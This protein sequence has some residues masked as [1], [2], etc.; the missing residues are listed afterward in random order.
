MSTKNRAWI[1][2]S[3]PKGMVT[4]DN[5]ELRESPVDTPSEGEFLIRT[6]WLSVDPYMRGRMN[7]RRTYIDPVALE[8]VMCG[9]G[10]GVVIE[11]KNSE[12]PVGCYVCGEFGWQEYVATNGKGMR[13]VDPAL[14]PLSTALGVLGMPG[15]TAYFGLLDIGKPQTGQTVVVSGA[16]GAVGATVG[17][18]AKI[19][20]CRVVGIA[21]SDE[22]VNYL[23][24]ELGFDAAWN[25]KTVPNYV[26]KLK[27]TCPTGIDIYFDNVGGPITDAVFHKINRKARI[28]ICG[29]IAQYNSSS[30][31]KGERFLWKLI[32][33]R[34][35]V[36]GFLVFDYAASYP[37]ADRQL[38]GWFQEGKLKYREKITRGL[39][40]TPQAFI[41]LFT[42]EN[43]GKQLVQVAD[44]PTR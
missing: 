20:G 7:D 13:R 14:A 33:T 11:S 43:I 35:R 23:T 25:Y 4:T 1:L 32:E 40:L 15:R 24:Q 18:I 38:I 42:G 8:S 29:Q 3:R 44:D 26:E 41:G 22:K 21:G 31:E 2:K 9:S 37:D 27:E 28:C 6:I 30:A 12:Y 34:S 19:Y 36:E 5:F 10:V 16:A 39:E 17:Q